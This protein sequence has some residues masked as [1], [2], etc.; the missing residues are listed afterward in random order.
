MRGNTIVLQYKQGRWN[1]T[2]P[3][4]QYDY[5]QKLIL[6]GVD[7]PAAYEVHFANVMH[8]DSKTSIGDGTGVEIPDEYLQTGKDVY[9]WLYLHSSENDGETE[10]AGMIPVT[11]RAKPTNEKPTPEQQDVITQTIAALNSAVEGV[12]ESIDAALQEA[13]ESGEFDGDDGVSPEVAVEEITGG[14]RVTITDAKGD[15][16]FDVMDGKT[17]IS[18]A[19]AYYIDKK[20]FKNPTSVNSNASSVINEAII[21]AQTKGLQFCIIPE[22]E[23]WITQTIYLK[24]DVIL[25]GCGMDATTLKIAD[26]CDIDAIRVAAPT[27]NSGIMDLSIDGNRIQNYSTY[28]NGHHGNAINVWLHYG[29]IER[30]RTDWVFKHSMLLNYDTGNS[31]DGLGF[32]PEHQND[33]GN[34]NKVLWCDFRDSLLQGVM[35]GWRTMDSWMCYT[36]IGSHAANLYMEGGTSRFIGNHFDGDGDNGAGPEYNVYCGDG[37]RAM[38]FEDNIFENTQKENIFFRQPSYSNQTMTITIA[39]NIIRTCSKS[40]N[41]QYANIKISGYSSSVPATEIVISGNQILNPDTNANHGYAG[42]HLLYCTNVKVVGNTFF[43]VG[44]DEVLLDNTCENVLDDGKM[45]E[46][47]SSLLTEINSIDE[48]YAVTENQ[49]VTLSWQSNKSWD[50]R[51]TSS[52]PRDADGY[53]AASAVPVLPGENYHIEDVYAISTSYRYPWYIYNSD[54]SSIVA[55]SGAVQSSAKYDYDVTIPE[56]GAWLCINC[57]SGTA[58]VAQGTKLNKTSKTYPVMG[59]VIEQLFVKRTANNVT[60]WEQGGFTPTTGARSSSSGAIRTKGRIGTEHGDIVCASGYVMNIYCYNADGEY[61]GVYKKS[62]GTIVKDYIAWY[63]SANLQTIANGNRYTFQITVKLDAGGSVIPSDASKVTIKTFIIDKLSNGIDDINASALTSGTGSVLDGFIFGAINGNN[64]QSLS[65]DASIRSMNYIPDGVKSIVT[66]GSYV[67]YLFAWDKITREYVGAWDQGTKTFKKSIEVWYNNL[68]VTDL[69]ASAYNMLMV[70]KKSDGSTFTIADAVQNISIIVDNIVKVDGD[71]TE[72]H[73]KDSL[74]SQADAVSAARTTSVWETVSGYVP[75]LT[76]LHFSDIHNDMENYPFIIDFKRNHPEIDDILNTG[77]LVGSYYSAA[78]VKSYF[79][80]FD[81]DHYA[82]LA[83]GNH[84]YYTSDNYSTKMSQ[85]T[86]Y[87]Y[88]VAPT[89]EAWGAEYTANKTYWY[90]DYEDSKV[91]LIGIDNMLESSD[92]TAQVTWLEGVLADALEKDLAVVIAGHCPPTTQTG[93]KITSSFTSF[94]NIPSSSDINALDENGAGIQAAVDSFMDDGGE[95][96]CYL[97]GHW[98]YDYLMYSSSYPNQL[99]ID[100]GTASHEAGPNSICTGVMR[101]DN[102]TMAQ[103][104]FNIF[105]VDRTDGLVRLV[106]IGADR[107]MY[108]KPRRVLCYDYKNHS[109]IYSE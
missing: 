5:G 33:M 22:G 74:E 94:Q 42:I 63:D 70:V 62:N 86:A 92:M 99:I 102:G 64:G 95:F 32:E 100:I 47:M 55:S 2:D 18:Q 59:E 54:F 109:L 29:R 12:Q 78:Q 83:L 61:L 89:I 93:V 13:K 39:N 52:T 40:Q 77:D 96:V 37:C 56:N 31:D 19:G 27:N 45:S 44:D 57:N 36:N 8:G 21:D 66:A 10:L 38:V 49:S 85:A 106:R 65:A 108:M 26:G 41:E 1:Q 104:L 7:L 46:E 17:E 76:L 3:L 16:P 97:M 11:K 73:K 25:C 88:Y 98:H 87:G 28:V 68:I 60:E 4:F 15:H 84:E 9:F 51:D 24:S 50:S 14:H 67:F 90:K 30:V 81:S 107:D 80:A 23:Y 91:R 34:L 105:T 6:E 43:N 35:W 101:R 20:L 53:Q 71:L 75:P 69:H 58:S 72:I 48:A 82:L 103:N 79:S